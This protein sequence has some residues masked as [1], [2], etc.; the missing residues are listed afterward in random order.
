M[1]RESVALV[2]DCV[3]DNRIAMQQNIFRLPGG[4]QQ[5]FINVN[6]VDNN[7]RVIMVVTFFVYRADEWLDKYYCYAIKLLQIAGEEICCTHL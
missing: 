2:F 7:C 5:K 6:F 4:D 3:T 1:K